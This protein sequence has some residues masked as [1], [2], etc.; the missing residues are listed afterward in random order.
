MTNVV[1]GKPL[2]ST[3]PRRVTPLLAI[4]ILPLPRLLNVPAASWTYWLDGHA[5][6]AALI[7]AAVDAV[8]RVEPYCVRLVGIPPPT[9]TIPSHVPPYGSRSAGTG[10]EPK[11]QRGADS[12]NAKIAHWVFLG[13]LCT[14]NL[15]DDSALFDTRWFS[16]HMPK[17]RARGCPPDR[18]E[19][20][21]ETL[22]KKLA[23]SATREFPAKPE[24]AG[25]AAQGL[26]QARSWPSRWGDPPR[27]WSLRFTNVP[28]WDICEHH[29]VAN[30]P[31]SYCFWKYG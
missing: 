30:E 19:F 10:S 24:P 27:N 21:I 1:A 4:L 12:K 8:L 9:P 22:C 15:H 29:K 26:T 28:K 18:S 7:C 5:A 13:A 31:R 14:L 16:K 25:R 17:K 11:T 6:I 20:I 23:N 2:T 3:A